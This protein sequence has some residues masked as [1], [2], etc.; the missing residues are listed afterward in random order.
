MQKKILKDAAVFLCFALAIACSKTGP[1]GATGPQG[2][3]GAQGPQ[4]PAGAQGPQG[5]ANVFTDTFTLTDANWLASSI[6]WYTVNSSISIGA[7]S[8]YADISFSKLTAGILD[9]GMVLV[10]F[11]SSTLNASMWTPIPFSFLAQGQQYYINYAYETSSGKVRLHYF[12]SA[13]ITGAVFPSLST[14]VI[15]TSKY[16]IIVVSGTIGNEMKRI[17][18]DPLNYQQTADYLGLQ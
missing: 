17:G 6:Y 16:K 9:S 3:Q 14:T 1:T 8:R 11:T 7:F 18:I 10:Y 4:G 12:F 2:S 5:N 13:N 15:P